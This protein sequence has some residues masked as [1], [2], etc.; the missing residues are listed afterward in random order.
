M[1]VIGDDGP[2]GIGAT[3]N[4]WGA[5][6]WKNNSMSGSV[7]NG[8]ASFKGYASSS[9]N[10]CGGTWGSRPGNSANPPATI[11]S[12][13]AIIVTSSVNKNGSNISG[14]IRKIILVDPSAGYGPNPGSAGSGVVAATVCQ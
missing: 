4:F 11:D 7:G 8:V 5:Q 3:V 1:F 10:F 6:W 9:D 2:H 13:I 12:R 14:N